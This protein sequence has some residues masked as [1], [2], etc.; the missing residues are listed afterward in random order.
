MSVM[1]RVRVHLSP[2]SRRSEVAGRHGDGWKVRVA[3]PAERGRANAA[4]EKL[5][6][7]ALA[8]PRAS[9]RIVAGHASRSKIVEVEGLEPVELERR[10]A[11]ASAP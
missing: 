2:G 11:E 8:V 4:L 10:L 6:A 9:V 1:S 7:E 5:V 3:A